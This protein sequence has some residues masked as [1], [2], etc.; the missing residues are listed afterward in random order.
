MLGGQFKEP[1]KAYTLLV[2]SRYAVAPTNEKEKIRILNPADERRFQAYHKHLLEIAKKTKKVSAKQAKIYW[3]EY[4]YWTQ[5]GFASWSHDYARNVHTAQGSSY[6]VVLVD[7]HDMGRIIDPN[8]RKKGMYVALSRA[9]QV[10]FW[11]GD[12]G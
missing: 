7:G 1:F 12:K 4:Y 3:T 6:D 8:V 5:A 9:R 10:L 2:R 11:V